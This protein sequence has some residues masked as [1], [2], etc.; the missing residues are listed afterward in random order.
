MFLRAEIHGSFISPSKTAEFERE[1]PMFS[2]PKYI[3]T[4]LSS[5]V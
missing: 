5:S 2:F 4:A 3:I 1:N